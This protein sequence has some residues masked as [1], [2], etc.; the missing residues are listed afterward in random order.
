MLL[1]LEGDRCDRLWH[2]KDDVEVLCPEK[3]RSTIIQPFGTSQRLALAA[4]AIATAIIGN[5]LVV[6]V[7]ALLDVTT[8]RRGSTQLDRR[9]DTTLCGRQ[10]SAMTLAIGFTVA[11]EHIR[12]FGP[13]A[14]HRLAVRSVLVQPALVRPAS[15][16]AA[17]RVDWR[18]H[19][20]WWWRSAGSVP[21]LPG[22][23]DQEAVEWSGHRCRIRASGRR[24]HVEGCAA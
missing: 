23:N 2:R 21:S 20:L 14:G 7:I 1:I 19:R 15:D 18:W 24:R 3:F 13:T 4:V 8:K 5:A 10:R 12:H 6:T 16:V 11:A 22:Y 9:H 17:G